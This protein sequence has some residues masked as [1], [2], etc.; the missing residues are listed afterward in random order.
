MSFASEGGQLIDEDLRE[1]DDHGYQSDH[2]RSGSVER[3]RRSGAAPEREQLM[4]SDLR[5][6][7]AGVCF[8]IALAAVPIGL[9]LTA[10]G[11]VAS[12]KDPEAGPTCD[13]QA[14]TPSTQ[15][16]RFGDDSAG[17]TSYEQAA[18]TQR[19]NR[20][21]AKEML[22]VGLVVLVI[23]IGAAAVFRSG[24]RSP[25]GTDPVKS[26]ANS[27]GLQPHRLAGHT[28]S[29]DARPVDQP[30]DRRP[31]STELDAHARAALDQGDPD[32]ALYW[33]QM[34]A[35]NGDAVAMN[36]LAQ[37][38]QDRVS[39]QSWLQRRRHRYRNAGDLVEA[40]LWFRKAAVAG[41]PDA[42]A[43]LAAILRKDGQYDE[44]ELWRRRATEAA[45]RHRPFDTTSGGPTPLPRRPTQPAPTTP[46]RS[47]NT[48]ASES[49]LLLMVMGNRSTANRLI[50]FEQRKDPAADRATS[51]RRA[52]ER[53]RE[54]RRRQG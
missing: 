21:S 32:T 6:L 31:S 20:E 7:S 8:L 16:W 2:R 12:L 49:E 11:G 10:V 30:R 18:R 54:D 44:A 43:N 13:G 46:D 28:Y 22:P 48:S 38:L 36:N 39:Q 1:G 23:G 52:I 9:I 45:S 29:L 37:L 17:V 41:N 15:C 47:E 24:T 4:T 25:A 40:G 19:A 35:N 50:D 14:M 26:Q 42:M 5:Q 34:A 3:S 51:V 53:L 33:F 27:S